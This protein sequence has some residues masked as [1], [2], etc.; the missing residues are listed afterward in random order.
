MRGGRDGLTAGGQLHP[1]SQKNDEAKI[2]GMRVCILDHVRYSCRYCPPKG[3]NL[4]P[5]LWKEGKELVSRY[6]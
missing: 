1:L 6:Y 3:R 4:R 2:H 5:D